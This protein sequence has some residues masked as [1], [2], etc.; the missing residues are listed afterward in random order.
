MSLTDLGWPAQ[1]QSAVT[2]LQVAGRA[3]FVL[4]CV[5]VGFAGLAIVGAVVGFFFADGMLG[6]GLN[7]VLDFVSL[8]RVVVRRW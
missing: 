2:A 7:F 3:M 5:G 8:S 4:Y 1:V 6:A